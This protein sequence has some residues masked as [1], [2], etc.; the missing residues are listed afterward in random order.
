MQQEYLLTSEVNREEYQL[1]KSKESISTPERNSLPAILDDTTIKTFYPEFYSFPISDSVY[2]ENNRAISVSVPN[3]TMAKFIKEHV[4]CGINLLKLHSLRETGPKRV[5][6]LGNTIISC[7]ECKQLFSCE[8]ILKLHFKQA[9]VNRKFLMNNSE[10]ASKD[11]VT[12]LS[13]EVFHDCPVCTER[14]TSY[15]I[16]ERHLVHQHK[17]YYLYKCEVCGRKFKR[18]YQHKQH[19][20]NYEM[21]QDCSIRKCSI[22]KKK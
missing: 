17:E 8:R 13:N 15:Y 1:S 5:L 12:A 18:K 2:L 11:K 4:Q 14:F 19:V 7:P 9:H 3:E 16:L 10:V 20:K 6:F 21:Y 22:C